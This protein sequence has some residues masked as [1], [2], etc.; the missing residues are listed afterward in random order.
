[1]QADTTKFSEHEQSLVTTPETPAPRDPKQQTRSDL[2]EEAFVRLS[3]AGKAELMAALLRPEVKG[4]NTPT[5][6][7]YVS[8]SNPILT[9]EEKGHQAE[10]TELNPAL[11]LNGVINEAKSIS[12]EEGIEEW[13]TVSHLTVLSRCC[14]VTPI[15]SY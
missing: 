15:A 5:G 3:D 1:M 2:W 9:P 11:V 6:S 4:S 10:A 14:I 8:V 13:K 7:G 12:D